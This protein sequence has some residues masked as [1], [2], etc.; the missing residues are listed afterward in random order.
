MRP[1]PCRCGGNVVVLNHYH[2]MED[3]GYYSEGREVHYITVVCATCRE[4]ET[5]PVF[6]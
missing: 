5:H 1:R 4:E 2:V 3:V 6:D